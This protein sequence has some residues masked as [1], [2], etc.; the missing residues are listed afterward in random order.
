MSLKMQFENKSPAWRSSKDEPIETDAT[1]ALC[2]EDKTLIQVRVGNFYGGVDSRM[3]VEEA[4]FLANAI[5][6]EA[7]RAERNRTGVQE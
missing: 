5:L 2:E 1:V 4:R 3:T 7:S 6:Y